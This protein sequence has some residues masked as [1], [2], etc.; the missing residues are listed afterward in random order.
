MRSQKI[1]WYVSAQWHVR[2]LGV[3]AN[4]A[5]TFDLRS[6]FIAGGTSLHG[7]YLFQELQHESAESGLTRLGR[8]V[9]VQHIHPHIALEEFWD[10]ISDVA[11]QLVERR[12]AGKAVLTATSGL[13]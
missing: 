12:F 6:F 13:K 10:H 11:Q 3:S 2:Q 5:V 4:S 8:L 1:F 7:F 9:E